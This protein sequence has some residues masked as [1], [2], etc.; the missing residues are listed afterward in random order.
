MTTH[1]LTRAAEQ[2]HTSQPTI[3]RELAAFERKLGFKLFERR[4]R[5]LYATEQAIQLHAAVTR[6]YQGIHHITEVARAILDN[7]TSH[8][9]IACLPLFSETLIPRV[10]RR[11]ISERADVRITFHSLDNAEMMRELIALHY[12]LGVVEIG[13]AVDGMDMTK[14]EIGD[15]VCIVPEGHRLARLDV[16]RPVDL[17]GEAFVGFPPDD[18]YRRRFDEIL[19]HA[20]LSKTTRIETN[21]AEAVCALVQQGA[22]VGL[23]NPISAWAWRG[24]GI[25]ARKFSVSIPFIAGICRPLGRPKNRLANHVTELLLDE[26]MRFRTELAATST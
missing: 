2:L 18:R 14:C 24:R 17:R 25:E 3:S 7:E 6:S 22:G 20:G 4:S 23:V 13:V 8:I 15:E 11:L 26:C 1:S 16:I 10:C 12:E 19:A 9:N 5:R 21:T